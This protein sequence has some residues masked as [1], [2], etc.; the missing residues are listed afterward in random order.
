VE[1]EEIHLIVANGAMIK[2]E[3]GQNG[4]INL[5]T[6]VVAQVIVFLPQQTVA[7]ARIV[8]T[9]MRIFTYNILHKYTNLSHNNL[10]KYYG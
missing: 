10:L 1:E 5:E 8:G 3:N 6:V 2:V 4:R 9:L 7:Q